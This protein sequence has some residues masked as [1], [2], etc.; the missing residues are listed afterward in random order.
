MHLS[1]CD[2]VFR[3][4]SRS[5]HSNRRNRM[6]LWWS[7]SVFAYCRRDFYRL[8]SSRIMYLQANGYRL[9]Q[10]RRRGFI[11]AKVIYARSL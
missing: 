1:G 5:E 8:T 6:C 3:S 4:A 10:K 7:R 11:K 9:Q 2:R